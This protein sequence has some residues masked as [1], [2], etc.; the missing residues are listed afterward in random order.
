MHQYLLITLICL[1]AG[2]EMS[3]GPRRGGAE[4]PG[5][6]PPA[7]VLCCLPDAG[8]R[9]GAAPQTVSAAVPAPGPAAA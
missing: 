5:G 4:G 7:A 8:L 9:A 6:G 1:S 3:G 2:A